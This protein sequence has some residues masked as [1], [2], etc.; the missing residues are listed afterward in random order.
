MVFCRPGTAIIEFHLHD[1]G[2]MDWHLAC[3]QMLRYLAYVPECYD[4]TAL[5]Y[6]IQPDRLIAAIEAV[7]RLE[8]RDRD[9]LCHR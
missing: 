1:T 6:R 9:R 2:I 3:T 4:A 8:P 5:S 7:A